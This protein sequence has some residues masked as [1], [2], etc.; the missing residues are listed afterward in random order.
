MFW[1]LCPLSAPTPISSSWGLVSR[2]LLSRVMPA[3]VGIL[4]AWVGGQARARARAIKQATKTFSHIFLF[5][6]QS[7][8]VLWGGHYS[9]IL[10]MRKLRLNFPEVTG[11]M[12]HRARVHV[13]DRKAHGVLSSSCCLTFSPYLTPA[14]QSPSAQAVQ[15]FA[16]LPQGHFL[17]LG[18]V[19]SIVGKVARRSCC[20]GLVCS[21]GPARSLW[22][23][24]RR[25]VTWATCSRLLDKTVF[26]PSLLKVLFIL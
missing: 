2:D 26:R 16:L 11:L 12:S 8:A 17:L 23:L 10:Q 22:T 1:L 5:L 18:N 14:P 9:F 6:I 20:V 24:C 7:L 21:A 15:P 3:H 25:L 19:F 4:E 13:H